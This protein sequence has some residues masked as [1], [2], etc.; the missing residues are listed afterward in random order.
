[1]A[2][3]Y[4]VIQQAKVPQPVVYDRIEELVDHVAGIAFFD[5][6]DA[7]RLQLSVRGRLADVR[8][9]ER[10]AILQ[11]LDVRV[12]GPDEPVPSAPIDRDYWH[13][14]LHGRCEALHKL[15]ETAGPE[16]LADERGWIASLSQA[17]ASEESLLVAEP[18]VDWSVDRLCEFQLP[19]LDESD[20]VAGYELYM[21]VMVDET[22]DREG[23]D[24]RD[25]Y[26]PVNPNA[27]QT[28][29]CVTGAPDL[30]LYRGG[31]QKDH[32]HGPN[33]A[34]SAS[35]GAGSWRLHVVGVAPLVYT[36]SGSW[37]FV[38]RA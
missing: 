27:T 8:R 38:R 5:I 12:L 6:P 18:E 7:G 35:G 4:P 33:S 16:E 19:S 37:I 28:S 36:L 2:E 17:L 10:T 24:P 21:D 26:K 31:A 34:V 20:Q 14:W 25:I 13:R 11:R 23:P 9:Y 15:I 30:F 1:M 3:H 29:A 32:D 22:G